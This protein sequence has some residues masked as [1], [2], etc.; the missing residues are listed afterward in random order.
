MELRPLGRTGLHV[1]TLCLGAFGGWGNEDPPETE[2]VIAAALDGGVNFVD[3]ADVYGRGQSEEIVGR[4]LA[5]G[6]RDRVVLA[7]KFAD[8]MGED[9]NQRGM[10]RRYI[11]QAVEA[12]LRRLRTDWIDLYQIHHLPPTGDLDEALG[13]LSD[14]IH[15]GKVRCIGTS[16][17]PAHRIVEAQWIAQHRGRERFVTEQ[18][19]YSLLARGVERDV[20]GVCQ[21]YGL[22]TLC[23]SPLGGGWLSGRYRKGSPA[24]RSV[25]A[26]VLPESYDP[27][28]PANQRKLEAA[29]ALAVLAESAGLSLIELALGFVLSIP[30]SPRPSSAPARP[31]TWRTTCAAPARAWTATSSTGSTRSSH[32]GRTSTPTTRVGSRPRSTTPASPAPRRGDSATLSV[33]TDHTPA[34]R[35]EST[36]VTRLPQCRRR[37]PRAIDGSSAALGTDKVLTSDAARADFRDPFQ[38]PASDDY[39][40]SAIVMPTTVEE[41]QEVVRVAN[42]HR[43]PLWAHA[44]GM[45]NGYGGPAPRVDGSVI[46]SLRN[47]NRVLEV[48]EESAYAV[49]EP[50]AS[51][52]DLYNAIRAGGHDLWLSCADIGWER[53]RQ[54]ARQRLHRPAL[55]R[56]TSR[57]RAGWSWSWPAAR[58]CGPAWARC[59]TAARGTS[60]AA[61]SGR[62]PEPLFIQSN[63]GIVTKMGVWLLPKPE[64]LHA[65]LDQ[66]LEGRRPRSAVRRHARAAA[67]P[68]DRG[69]P[70]RSSTRC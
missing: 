62:R 19:L 23:W 60:T 64:V 17:F 4:A 8:P 28:L 50:G 11:V 43:V 1:S 49:V 10:S 32:R 40:A 68:H 30:R 14:L 44:R 57:P 27:D 22:A 53:R 26:A 41:V 69:H 51:W 48:N 12:S 37:V 25:R 15:A 46:V 31:T 66:G 59:P 16:N 34:P 35:P 47:M 9:P 55:R 13:A 45:N 38:H 21:R 54:L 33:M 24:P 5:G 39:M 63:Y 7:T 61:A 56:P 42:E 67:R 20:L 58:S 6:R 3:T 36:S 29:D 65:D 18:A 52:F 70:A 2:R